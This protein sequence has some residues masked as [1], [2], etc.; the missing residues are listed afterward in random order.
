MLFLTLFHSFLRIV[1]ATSSSSTSVPIQHSEISMTKDMA[2]IVLSSFK[3][4]KPHTIDI[5]GEFDQ[6][7][8][9]VQALQLFVAVW[10][11]SPGP[12]F[13]THVA[14]PF[15][16]SVARADLQSVEVQV[17]QLPHRGSVRRS[18]ACF[19]SCTNPPHGEMAL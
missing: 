4:A 12:F 5:S 11:Q 7:T 15:L 13:I 17:P 3:T 1:E 9:P 2:I 18:P 16:T 6:S 10:G 8:C 14:R 19:L